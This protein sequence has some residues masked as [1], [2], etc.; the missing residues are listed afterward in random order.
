MS[1]RTDSIERRLQI[2]GTLL[3]LALVT[4]VLCLFWARPLSFLMFITIGGVLLFF[5]VLV[6]LLSLL[7]M[8]RSPDQDNS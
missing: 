3:I 1:P 2:A 5:G 4:E 8:K 7:S 6:Y